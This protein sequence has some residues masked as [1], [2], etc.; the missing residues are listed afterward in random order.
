MSE[1]DF[2]YH[3]RIKIFE[4]ANKKEISI[5]C[6]C[7]RYHVSRKWFYKWKK[8]RD[9]NGD[10]GLRTKMRA[11]PKMPNKVP[12]ELE[13]KILEFIKD[14]PTYGPA[15]IEAELS[16]KNIIVGHTGIYN[17]LQRRGLNTVKMRLEWIRKL[18]G[19]IVTFDELQRDKEKSKTNHIEANYPG[20][21]V[22][23]DT[24][25]I[26]YLKGI[27][28]I[29]HQVACDCFSSFGLAKIYT[30]KT[31]NT[32]CDFVKNHLAK[33]FDTVKIE[34]ILTDCGTEYTT[35]H[36]EAIPNHEFEKMCKKLGIKHTTTK[37]RH[38][39]TNGYVE[40]LNETILNEFYSLAF[41]KKRYESIEKLQDD[42]DGFMDYY[43]Y[44][45]THQGYKLKKNG[46]ATPAEAHLS[47]NSKKCLTR[48]F[49][50]NKIKITM[51]NKR[52]G[53]EEK[54]I[55]TGQV[56]GYDFIRRRSEKEEVLEC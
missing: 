24:F 28:R 35:W 33:K 38:P 25:Y 40:R 21:L 54:L 2:I 32:S 30:N 16:R 15:R 47:T 50:I 13:G 18:N 6:F 1:K 11:N 44:R 53:V 42:L 41:R 20:Q 22:S 29:Y 36:K 12:V 49:G 39:W 45:R 3:M 23:E 34:R 31:V 14:Y 17:V 48:K 43:N 46:Y 8:R 51:T 55:I 5:T 4:E 52:K 56:L 9:K 26:G 27:G 37:V 19:E 10:N 7:K